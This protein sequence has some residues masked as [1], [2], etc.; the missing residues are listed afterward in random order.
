MS[1]LFL[2]FWAPWFGIHPLWL[3]GCEE[4]AIGLFGLEG[5]RDRRWEG[6]YKF[7]SHNENKETM[8]QNAGINTILHIAKC[9]TE[10]TKYQRSASVYAGLVYPVLGLMQSRRDGHPSTVLLLV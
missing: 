3:C 7:S 4:A 6:D 8:Q 9:S 1:L 10:S 5:L 2:F